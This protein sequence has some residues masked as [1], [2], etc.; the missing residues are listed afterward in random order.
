[1]PE[2]KCP[3]CGQAI[4]A[5]DTVELRNGIEIRHVD[6]QQPRGLS[7]EERVLLFWH[8]WN[9]HA[10]KCIACGES[11]RP[12]Q[13]AADPF[14]N[15]SHL[16]PHCRRNLTESLRGH[17]FTCPEI[18][19]IVRQRAREARDAARKLVKKSVQTRDRADV[20][21]REAEAAIAALRET[22]WRELP[23]SRGSSAIP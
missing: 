15:L 22:M 21:M 3:R 4:A 8:C 5:D 7:S 1:M 11:F 16:C 17:V 12:D 9:H 13:L 14:R 6:C 10:A 20:L 18:H 23:G 19:Q 2:P